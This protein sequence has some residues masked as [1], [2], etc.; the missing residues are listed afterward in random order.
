LV[1]RKVD[2]GSARRQSFAENDYLEVM[3]A[4]LQEEADGGGGRREY[5]VPKAK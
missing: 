1:A 5:Q 3:G 4:S 2:I